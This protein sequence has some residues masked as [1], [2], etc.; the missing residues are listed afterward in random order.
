MQY[1]IVI[2]LCSYHGVNKRGY[3]RHVPAALTHLLFH[4]TA[5]SLWSRT[6]DYSDHKKTYLLSLHMNCIPPWLM[7]GKIAFHEN[8]TR[9]SH[10]QMYLGGQHLVV[11]WNKELV[12]FVYS[13]MF[14]MRVV[15]IDVYL[16]PLPLW[17]K[18]FG[19]IFKPSTFKFLKVACI[20]SF[21]FPCVACS[22][23][24]KGNIYH[25]QRGKADSPIHLL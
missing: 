6:S 16:L 11:C 19:L 13:N 10:G 18:V 20:A 23:P 24:P 3:S 12:G 4:W 1:I 5:T 21:L 14:Y 25:S 9:S 22:L 15:G 17:L 7:I 2:I 8:A